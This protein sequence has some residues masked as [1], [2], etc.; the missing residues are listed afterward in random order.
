[1]PPITSNC[2]NV[3]EKPHISLSLLAQNHF[4]FDEKTQ[5]LK[6][7]CLALDFEDLLSDMDVNSVTIKSSEL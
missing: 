1:M 3:V 6:H 5:V 7:S 2:K 4:N